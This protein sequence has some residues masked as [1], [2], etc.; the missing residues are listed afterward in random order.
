MRVQATRNKRGA[1]TIALVW[2]SP[3][4]PGLS[5]TLFLFHSEPGVRLGRQPLDEHT[6]EELERLNPHVEFD[7]PRI[8]RAVAA[9]AAVPWS[10]PA[11]PRRRGPGDDAGSGPRAKRPTTPAEWR[12]Y[13]ARKRER[14]PQ[15]PDVDDGTQTAASGPED[16]D[17]PAV[18]PQPPAPVV[19]AATHAAVSEEPSSS[20]AI[21]PVSEA[22]TDSDPWGSYRNQHEALLQRVYQRVH[23]GARR[24]A[25]VAELLAIAPAALDPGT[26]SPGELQARLDAVRRQLPRRRR[27]NKRRG[28]SQAGVVATDSGAAAEQESPDVE[29]DASPDDGDADSDEA[30]AVGLDDE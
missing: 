26:A 14:A 22:A 11:D 21:A 5:R 2:T 24:Q 15:E 3:R 25:L 13:R 12:E 29:L 18:A 10:S 9:A 1:E 8:V 23:D 28:P 17:V 7:W 27:R 6:M 16:A 30:G 20:S 4:D 19:L